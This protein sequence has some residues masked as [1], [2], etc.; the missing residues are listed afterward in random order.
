MRHLTKFDKFVTGQMNALK[1]LYGSNLMIPFLILFYTT[2]DILGHV[3]GKG[4][5]GFI[6][7]YIVKKLNNINAMDL[8]GARC[9]ILHTSGPQ[10]EHS[11]KAKARQILYCW[12]SAKIEILE[13]VIAKGGEPD[14]YMAASIEELCESLVNGIAKF[15][16][17]LSANPKLAAICDERVA[18][19]YTAINSN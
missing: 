19:F 11:K 4:F 1:L 7:K 10:S 18:G 17:E 15:K 13:R 5:D 8:W 16:E 3:S 9:S 6:N 2:I 14:K 12:G